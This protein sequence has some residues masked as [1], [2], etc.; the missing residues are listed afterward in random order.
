MIDDKVLEGQIP[1]F[2]EESEVKT[3]KK[4]ESLIGKKLRYKSGE[5][6][7]EIKDKIEDYKSNEHLSRV[8]ETLGQN[9]EIREGWLEVDRKLLGERDLYYPQDWKFRIRP[10]T[11]EAIRNWSTIDD[12]NVLSVDEVFNEILKSCLSI[13]TS[14]GILPWGNL[15]PWDRLWFI[16]L[17]REYTFVE[18]ETAIVYKEPCI[19]C[20]NDVEYRL[21]SGNLMYEMPD[22]EVMKHFSTEEQTWFIN[23]QDYDLDWP[24]PITLYLPTLEKEAN[25]KAWMINKLQQN[26]N[27]K[28]DQVFMHFLPWMA[29]KIAKDLTIAQRQ[30]REYEIKFKSWDEDMFLFM[31]DVIKNINVIPSTKLIAK[32]E[33]CGEENTSEI[34]FPDGISSLFNVS[35]KYKKFGKK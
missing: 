7:K 4:E 8:G 11:V 2:K 10:A 23:P 19:E 29:P 16:L 24:E 13:I 27:A 15:H 6:D 21:S 14:N 3:E 18:G 17:I 35:R 30:I 12:E 5:S 26:R 33:I 22:S 9:A 32:C 34:R 28:I 31:D 20:D 1:E 25:I